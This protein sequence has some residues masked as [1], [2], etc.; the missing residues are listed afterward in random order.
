MGFATQK[1]RK[2]E[3]FTQHQLRQ[4]YDYNTTF[5]TFVAGCDFAQTNCDTCTLSSK[6]FSRLEQI[7]DALHTL[8]YARVSYL[9]LRVV[10]S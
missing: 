10:H 5:A 2:K 7:I 3:S 9:Q 8:G 1:K 6:W 4:G